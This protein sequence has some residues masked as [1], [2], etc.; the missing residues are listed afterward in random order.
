MSLLK[1]GRYTREDKGASPI[2]PTFPALPPF[3]SLFLA[4]AFSTG[5]ELNIE[6]EIG[7]ELGASYH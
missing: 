5:D 3:F 7:R 2:H 1:K 4:V 6:G